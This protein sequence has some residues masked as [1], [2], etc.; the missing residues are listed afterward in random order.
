MQGGDGGQGVEHHDAERQTDDG[1]ADGPG[2]GGPEQAEPPAEQDEVDGP[3]QEGGLP[4]GHELGSA[5]F[6]VDQPGP[7]AG[8]EGQDLRNAVDHP[9]AQGQAD[10]GGVQGPGDENPDA[11]QFPAE[12]EEPEDTD[13]EGDFV[14]CSYVFG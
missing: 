14:F 12:N 13:D 6:A 11:G 3:D 8:L 9:Q 1:A 5:I 2:Q 4:L 7:G 10:Y